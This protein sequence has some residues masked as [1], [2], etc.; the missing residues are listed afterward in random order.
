MAELGHRLAFEP[1]Y[2]LAG[3]T[4]DMPELPQG[5]RV[6]A[7]ESVPERDVPGLARAQIRED[8]LDRLP[9]KFEGDPLDMNL[10]DDGA[11]SFRDRLIIGEVDLQP[12]SAGPTG[13]Q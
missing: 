9:E 4:V 11:T 3:H 2:A 6:P 1:A 13:H 10:T 8:S 7:G 5:L 12:R